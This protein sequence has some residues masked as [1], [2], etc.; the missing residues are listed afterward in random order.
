MIRGQK[1]IQ[2]LIEYLELMKLNR[3]RRYSRFKCYFCMTKCSREYDSKNFEMFLLHM[4]RHTDPMKCSDVLGPHACTSLEPFLTFDAMDDHLDQ[5]HNVDLYGRHTK[6]KQLFANIYQKK[7]KYWRG[8]SKEETVSK[9]QTW[10][11]TLM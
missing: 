9:I 1:S 7:H 5:H 4:L 8:L 10:L 3:Q 11:M 6:F 2:E